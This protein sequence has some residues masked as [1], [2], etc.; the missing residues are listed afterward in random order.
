MQFDNHCLT[1]EILL[2]YKQAY[3]YYTSHIHRD[4]SY[5]SLIPPITPNVK[6]YLMQAAHITSL[7]VP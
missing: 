6:Q 3:T 1:V 5:P 7:R 2:Y 4:S